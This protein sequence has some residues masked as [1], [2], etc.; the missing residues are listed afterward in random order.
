VQDDTLQQVSKVLE[1]TC[2]SYYPSLNQA[3]HVSGLIYTPSVFSPLELSSMVM[4]P[5]SPPPS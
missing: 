3:D 1:Q 2:S 4:T 5:V